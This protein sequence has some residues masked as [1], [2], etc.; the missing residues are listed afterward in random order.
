[1]FKFNNR[2]DVDRHVSQMSQKLS[3]NEVNDERKKSWA[4]FCRKIEKF[5]IDAFNVMKI[6]DKL[7]DFKFFT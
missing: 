7:K 5:S 6:A 3:E 1:M 2:R 4:C